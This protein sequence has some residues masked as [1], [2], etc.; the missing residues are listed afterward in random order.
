MS[1]MRNANQDAIYAHSVLC[2]ISLFL[3]LYFW[4]GFAELLGL[5]LVERADKNNELK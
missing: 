2:S 3:Y 4:Q 1:L 5:N